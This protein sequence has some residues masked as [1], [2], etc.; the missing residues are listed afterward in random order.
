[1]LLSSSNGVDARSIVALLASLSARAELND[2][3]L[4]RASPHRRIAAR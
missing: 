3:H 2:K 1:V 4:Q